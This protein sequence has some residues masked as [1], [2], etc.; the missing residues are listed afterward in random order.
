MVYLESH[1]SLQIQEWKKHDT[2]QRALSS[3]K[4]TTLSHVNFLGDVIFWRGRAG[5]GEKIFWFEKNETKRNA[6]VARMKSVPP[7]KGPISAYLE[8][9]YTIVVLISKMGVILLLRSEKSPQVCSPTT[10]G[11]QLANSWRTVGEL[12]AGSDGVYSR[13]KRFF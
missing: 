8:R 3:S 2:D 13:W 5:E 6:L 9:Q 4:K 10:V 12:Y 7:Y 1:R 11:E